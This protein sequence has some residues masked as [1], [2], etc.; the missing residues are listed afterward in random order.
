MTKAVWLFP[1]HATQY[2]QRALRW[3]REDLRWFLVS[4]VINSNFLILTLT[5][6][7]VFFYNCQIYWYNNISTSVSHFRFG[8]WLKVSLPVITEAPIDASVSLSPQPG[9]RSLKLC[10]SNTLKI[11]RSHFIRRDGVR[12]RVCV[13]VGVCKSGEIGGAVRF[14]ATD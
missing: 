10:L 14:C 3:W 7:A 12:M 4:P 1:L 9:S 5:I 2:S 11:R 6:L 13:W 8:Y